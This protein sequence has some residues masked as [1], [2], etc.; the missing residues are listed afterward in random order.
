MA[1]AC[2]LILLI[3]SGALGTADRDSTDATLSVSLA[4]LNPTSYA[5]FEDVLVTATVTLSGSPALGCDVV[6]T[7][8]LNPAESSSLKDDGI[9]PD[10]LADNGIYTGYF[11]IGGANGSA[12]VAKTGNRITV[13]A[14]R[15][16]DS[17]SAQSGTFT[18]F[19]AERWTG[20]TTTGL[21][22]EPDNHDLYTNFVAERNSVGWHHRIADFGVRSSANKNGALIRVPIFPRVNS[23]SNLT[24]VNG[25]DAAVMGNVIQFRGN[26]ING[27]TSRFTIEFDSPSDLAATY[28]DRYNTAHIGLRQFRNG[29]VV[30][31]AH[32]SQAIFGSPNLATTHGVG[33][34]CGMQ[35]LEKSSGKMRSIDCM[36]RV[37]IVCD[38]ALYN[39]GGSYPYNI[40]WQDQIDNSWLISADLTQ[41]SFRTESL[42]TYCGGMLTVGKTLQF[43]ADEHYIRQ[44]YTIENADSVPHSATIVWGREQWMY[45]DTTMLDDNDRGYIGTDHTLYGSG[46]RVQG[47]AMAERFFGAVDIGTHYSLAM[48][49]GSEQYLPTYVYFLLTPPLRPDSG[50]YPVDYSGTGTDEGS[51]FF[52]KQ[53]GTL[54]PG[55]RAYSEFYMWG[56]YGTGVADLQSMVAADTQEIS[57]KPTHSIPIQAGW[58]LVSIPLETTDTI[59]DLLSG[60]S[61]KWDSVKYY[62]C[63]DAA[64]PW[65]TNRPGGQF[66]D[67]AVID[68]GMGIWLHATENCVLTV[69][70]IQPASTGIILKS[71]WN[72]VGYPSGTNRTVADALAGT[73]YDRVEIFDGAS[74]C[75]IA[76]AAPSYIMKP[77]EG[78][79]ILVPSDTVWTVDW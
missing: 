64:D 44:N 49:F 65:K 14:T 8:A 23:V 34:S 22:T 50:T 55:E 32:V 3:S 26:L 68:R 78:Y 40:K 2:I 29:Y 58:N 46:Y 52:E 24:V 5:W 18:T 74:P 31:N 72:L 41:M 17:G 25:T 16:G 9:S 79:W 4:A 13:T 76:E 19:A 60:I 47:S 21:G 66:N 36:E 38:G 43:H 1:M 20:V 69:S 6:A 45:G 54:G 73:N 42:G 70:G 11:R 12:M 57:S 27:G 63:T 59:P 35:A 15:P 71:G 53:F 56:G 61:G 75:L 51:T 67:L 7:S 33:V 77:G 28:I 48:I 37:G 62:D 30:W 39:S 10:A